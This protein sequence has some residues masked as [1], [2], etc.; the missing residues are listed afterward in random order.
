MEV[1]LYGFLDHVDLMW[2][3]LNKITIKPWFIFI[4]EDIF[5]RIFPFRVILG[6][7]VAYAVSFS[8]AYHVKYV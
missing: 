4:L 5:V 2:A 3:L 1:Q 6:I 8:H 7:F